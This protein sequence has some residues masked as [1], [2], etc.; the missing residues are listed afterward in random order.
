MREEPSIARSGARKSWDTENA[1]ASSSRFAASS[2]A[3]REAT[4]GSSSRL[5]W[6]TVS[7]ARLLTMS[8]SQLPTWAMRCASASADSLRR[9]VVSARSHGPSADGR[10]PT[11]AQRRAAPDLPVPSSMRPRPA[12]F[13]APAEIRRRLSILYV[14]FLQAGPLIHDGLQDRGIRTTGL[15]GIR[16]APGDVVSTTGSTARTPAQHGA[17]ALPLSVCSAVGPQNGLRA[18]RA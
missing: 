7:S 6:R 8:R 11:P 12:K 14:I 3:V 17:S 9:S 13:G 5:I 2:S 4:R 18:D 1:K 15:S 10:H 16:P